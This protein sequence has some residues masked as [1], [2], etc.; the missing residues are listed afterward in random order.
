MLL[1]SSHQVCD[2]R[3][4]LEPT[5]TGATKARHRRQPSLPARCG[6]GRIR[7]DPCAP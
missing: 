4:V 7:V 2:L 6:A 3:E 1:G 5:A